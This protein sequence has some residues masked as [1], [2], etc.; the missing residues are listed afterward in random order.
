MTEGESGSAAKPARGAGLELRLERG[1]AYVALK[2]QPLAPSVDLVALSMEI[3]GVRFP[4]DSAGGAAQ[5]RHRLCELDRLE[6]A[7]AEPGLA[8]LLAQL[9]LA[10]SGLASLA[11]ALRAGFAE[12]TG[13]LEGGAPFTFKVALLP[14]SGQALE[15][16]V[17]E[18]RIYAPAPVCAA[19]LPALLA[20]AGLRFARAEGLVLLTEPLPALL[21]RLLPARGWK[22][23]RTAAARLALAEILPGRLGLAWD[24]SGAA[25]QPPADPDLMAAVEGARA[26][27]VA[28]RHLAAGDAAAARDAYLALGPTAAA[29]LFGASR[30]LALLSADSTFHDQ[31]LDLAADALTRRADFAPALLAVAQVRAARGERALAAR[32]FAALAAAAAH[33]GEDG[34][35]LAAADACLGL[36]LD[37]DADAQARAVETALSLRRDHLPALRALLAL[38]ERGDPEGLLRACRRLAAYAPTAE[39]KAAAHARLGTL[40]LGSDPP[41]ARL[42]LDHALRLAPSDPVALAAL[43]RAC[44][45]GGD[46]LRAV[47]A[48]DRLRELALARGDRPAAAAA[49]LEVAALW[50]RAGQ[51]ENAL[52]RCR[53]ACELAPSADAREHTARL[54]ETLGQGAEAAEHWARVLEILDPAAEGAGPRLAAAHRALA[55]H[56]D[57]RLGDPAASAQHLEAALHHAPHDL[58]AL[59]HL[60]RLQTLLGRTRDRRDALDRLAALASDAVERA[61]FLAEAARLSEGEPAEARWRWEGALAAASF[62][63]SESGS[64]ATSPDPVPAG[65]KPPPYIPIQ[66]PAG[67]KP[68]P[69]IPIQVPAGDKPPPYV[70]GAGAQPA[71]ALILEALAG[72]ARAA[73]AQG[74]AAAELGAL[75]QLAL[76]CE[77]GAARAAALDRLAA[78]LEGVSDTASALAAAGAAR[79]EEPTR[80]RLET[81]LR[82]ARHAGDGTRAAELLAEVA[83]ATEE[84]HPARAARAQLERAR[85]LA[86]S[87]HAELALAAARESARRDPSLAEAHETVAAL[88]AGRDP[89]LE[90]AA[91][92][93]RAGLAR[94]AASVDAADRLAVAG[95][96]ALAAGLADEGEA[97]LREAIAIGL[98]REAAA[99]AWSAL[100]ARAAGRKDA[101]AERAALEAAAPLL[102][103]DAKPAA[104]LRLSALALSAGDSAGARRAAEQ[105]RLLAPRD[106]ISAEACRAAAEAQGDVAALPDLL[107]ALAAL[108]PGRAGSL[109]LERARRLSALGRA[110]EADRAMAE[111]LAAL[112]PDAEL[113]AEHT[114]RRQ[115]GP[116]PLYALP[117]GE[118]LEAFAQRTEDRLAGGKALREAATLALAQGDGGRALRCARGAFARTQDDLGFAG[119]LLAHVLY[120]MGAAA[121]ALALHRRLLEAGLPGTEEGDAAA[122]CRELAELAEDAGDVPLALEA[123]DRLIALQP[124]EVEAALRRFELD[125]DR[126]RA[127]LALVAAAGGTRRARVRADALARAAAAARTELADPAVSD[128]LF[129]RARTAAG[130]YPAALAHV[131]ARRVEAARAE[132]D[133]AAPQPPM[134][135]LEALRDLAAA[136]DAAGDA[137]GASACFEEMAERA[138]R[139]GLHE[140]AVRDLFELERRDLAAGD[141]AASARHARAA[142]ALLLE[143]RSDPEGAE[144]ALRRA[145]ARSPTDVDGWRALEAAGR[146]RGEA[147][148]GTVLESLLSR[149]SLCPDD[150]APRREAAHLLLA[151]G[152][153]EDAQRHLWALARA[154]PSDSASADAL[155]IAL[156]DQ[157]AERAELFLLRASAASGTARAPLLRE[158]SRALLAAG[159]ESGARAAARDAFGADPADDQAFRAALRD[160]SGELSQL[161]AVLATRAEAV[162][163]DA[164]GCHRARAD[165][166]FA[167]GRAGDALVAYQACLD[168]APTDADVLAHVADA[169]ARHEGEAAAAPFDLRIAVLSEETAGVISPGIEARSRFRLGLA[170]AEEGH[171]EDATRH[172]ARALALAPEDTR[173]R[174]ALAALADAHAALGENEAALA[175]ARHL[176]EDANDE[177]A[178]REALELGARLAARFG[179]RGT[180]SAGLLEGL[181][182]LSLAREGGDVAEGLAERA[183]DALLRAGENARATALVALAARTAQGPRRAAWLARLAAAA[184]AR[185]D[186]AAARAER[187]EAL[188]A[189]PSDAVL[190]QAHLADL[191]A[192]GDARAFAHAVEAALCAPGADVA[193]LS[194]RRARALA[195]LGDGDGAERSFAAVFDLGPAAPG[196]E[197]SARGLV[198]LLE[199]RGDLAGAA[200]FELAR[201]GASEDVSARSA[202]LLAAASFLE[203]CG[204]LDGARDAAE[205]A[206]D[207]EPDRAAPWQVLAR[208]ARDAG[209][210]DAA[211]R[212]LLAV[213][214]RSEGEASAD[215]ALEAASLLDA[216]GR[217]A[218]AERALMAAV[219]A[220]PGSPAARR[221]LSDRAR[222]AGDMAGAARHLASLHVAGLAPDER[223]AH[224]RALARA[225]SEAGDPGAEAA[226]QAVFDADPA[227]AEAF[228]RVAA[229]ARGRGESERWLALAARHEGALSGTSDVARRR[230]LRCERAALLTDLGQL[231][232]AEGTWQAALA[233][234]QRHRGAARALRALLER[235]CDHAG[236]ADVLAVEALAADDPAEAAELLLDEAR[237]RLEKLCDHGRCAS[238]LDAAAERLR[239]VPGGRAERILAQAERMRAEIAPS[240]I[241]K[242]SVALETA[243]ARARETLF[244]GTTL[245][246]VAKI[247]SAVAA[248]APPDQARR[249]RVLARAAAGIA[250]FAAGEV[251]RT[252]AAPSSLAV[253]EEAHDRAAH[254]LARSAMAR[255]VA[256]LAPWLE[257]LFPADLSRRAVSGRHRVGARRAPELLALM[258]DVQRAL[259]ARPFAAFLSDAGGCEIGVENTQPP[260]LVLGAG[261]AGTLTPTE[262]RF[263]VARGL[264]LV[265]LGWSLVGKFAPRDVAILCELACRFAGAAPSSTALSG[266]HAQPFLD[267]LERLVP[268]TVRERAAALA[269][270][271]A[272]DLVSLAP[273]ELAAALRQ[274]ASRLA[275]LHAGDP[276]AALAALALGERLVASPPGGQ[277]LSHPDLHDLAAFALSESHLELRAAAE[278]AA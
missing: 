60:E 244:D 41:A 188:L 16:V 88:A 237:L 66:V 7:I 78:A 135:L 147:G 85:L 276:R 25:T 252:V 233:L 133:P 137:P 6:L 128:A 59:R 110:E 23:P 48:L 71:T 181:A 260:S 76:A 186:L 45:R 221:A 212:A 75:E 227:D 197:E 274:T 278:C 34:A 246:E 62:P 209:D 267:A 89:A 149:A 240:L 73:R 248:E 118:P 176:V 261:L 9:A 138:A 11:L 61:S 38:G 210:R 256:L 146:A 200:R 5:F 173:A 218:E 70:R 250:A 204:D 145:V 247:A 254:P 217:P 206:R 273:R 98:D 28:E 179:D 123:L 42:H 39:E 124:H 126:G 234:D 40:L 49:S 93:A 272:R 77:P 253:G 190:L 106:P 216:A 143:R 255:L 113:A 182:A 208:L 32:A 65:D 163:A 199:A 81:A 161:D 167:S 187:D 148:A 54:A 214:I 229:P 33:R 177:P 142:G 207:A 101:E 30:L 12:G 222:D 270:E 175:A 203:R 58:E 129:A 53:E 122:L 191:E 169:R 185:G 205:Q 43:A 120:R 83:A 4:F 150:P 166:L 35:A 97:A 63:N 171:A 162:P 84:V 105:A 213:A 15:V 259:R 225:L 69:Y 56:A 198:A 95:Q 3:P 91:L 257:G 112:P 104:L 236:A 193:A 224:Q 140:E 127:V 165:A 170:A 10:D 100:A 46:H 37:A 92:L 232:A 158:A 87:G 64:P 192:A 21:R 13:T 55:R 14:T 96:A 27:A 265:D 228:E 141:G 245:A 202:A 131:E 251:P 263:L 183:V 72:V 80:E 79:A 90:A 24:R 159:D 18:P 36:G 215:A 121:E 1:G 154:D 107:A 117:W 264:A 99:A 258:E 172:L 139:H 235:R 178:R 57:E 223:V 20:R 51:P 269:P 262:Q 130:D 68:P 277:A 153:T 239:G 271:A 220:L 231:D 242:M 108:E 102:L 31:A 125:P 74:D 201:A 151:L 8:A 266:E 195:A 194:L 144:A 134:E 155:A 50:E 243:L 275:L 136:R 180:D 241:V 19:A 119:P 47:R 111:A 116:A 184:A 109:L 82:L 44:E 196:W 26:F 164:A 86:E 156:T 67:D 160:A 52:L 29:H 17:Y 94:H 230:D 168:H 189:D 114:R 132:Y 219:A 268:S 152:R 22:V 226:W 238:V 174:R 211:A 115:D 2:P 157:H 103:T 249:L